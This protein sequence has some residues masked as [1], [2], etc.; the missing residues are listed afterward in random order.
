MNIKR[1]IL[2]RLPLRVSFFIGKNNTYKLSRVKCLKAAL[3]GFTPDEYVIFNL[4][5]NNHKNYLKE[6]E[7]RL[8]RDK[9]INYRIL[10][11]N[12]LVFYYLIKDIAPVNTL[13]AYKS[14]GVFTGLSEGIKTYNNIISSIE[15]KGYLV[16]KPIIDGG[17]GKGFVLF[18]FKGNCFYKNRKVTT[19][20]EIID[21]LEKNDKYLIEE[22]C[23]QSD[24]E[25]SIFPYTVNTLR[26]ITIIHK[27]GDCEC[28]TALQR[29]GTDIDACADNASLG[30]GFCF[31]D[32]STGELSCVYTYS[33]DK[34]FVNGKRIGVYTK[35]PITNNQ[36]KGLVIPNFNNIVKQITDVHKSIKFTGANFVAWDI[37]LTND[38]FKII[39]AN[40]SCGLLFVQI[41]RGARYEALGR[42]FKENGFIK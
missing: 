42:W 16:C 13:I 3:L 2:R 21:F 33:P 28:V 29:M 25:N 27:D 4:D 18:E 5:V 26:L 41:E 11:D 20:K 23:V 15:H 30:G 39:E 7:R 24:F 10:F 37:A 22:Y 38:G 9:V 34:L 12:K 36:I 14:N 40:T 17:G 1:E 6:Y 31:V 32:L 35:H 8:F 19:E